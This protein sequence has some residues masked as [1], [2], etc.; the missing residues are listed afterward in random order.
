MSES[1]N[2]SEAESASDYQIIE[3]TREPIELYKVLK[4]ENMVNSGGEAKMVIGSGLVMVN[5]AVETQK[6]KKIV[7]GDKIQFDENKFIMK[8]STLAADKDPKHPERP[9]PPKKKA[10]SRKPISALTKGSS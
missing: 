2:D 5:G 8:L 4:F 10:V 7:S 9:K 1:I 6:R 3:L